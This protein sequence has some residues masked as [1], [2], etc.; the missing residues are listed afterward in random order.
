ML[1]ILC[2]ACFLTIFQLGSS[3]ALLVILISD[4]GLLLKKT[5]S[6]SPSLGDLPDTPHSRQHHAHYR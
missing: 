3:N 1:Q 5:I 2:V 6:Q 4:Y